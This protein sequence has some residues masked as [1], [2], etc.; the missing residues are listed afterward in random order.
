MATIPISLTIA[1]DT[2][3]A[4]SVVSLTRSD[5]GAAPA[6]VTIP[7]ALTLTSDAWVGSFVDASPPPYYTVI[8]SVT[9]SDSSV[10]TMPAFT[11][12]S[13]ASPVGIYFSA[14]DMRIRMGEFNE[15]QASDPDNAGDANQKILHEQDAITGA[16]NEMH[17]IMRR[18][19]Y[20]TPA[21]VNLDSMKDI[22][23]DVG[24]YRLYRIRGQQDKADAYLS[25]HD[26]AIDRLK[27][28]CF[29]NR[30]RFTPLNV[31]SPSQAMGCRTGLTGF[32]WRC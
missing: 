12:N 24:V 22:G 8:L 17:E 4:V 18:D 19:N 21:T 31:Q 13:G 32:G 29:G 6:G 26:D 30:G 28:L 11:L 27:E 7:F 5:T 15:S 2:V 23:T 10:Q 1:G 16:E 20:V 3:S 25:I 9:Y 14:N